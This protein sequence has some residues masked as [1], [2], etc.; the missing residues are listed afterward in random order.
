MHHLPEELLTEL[1]ERSTTLLEG[2]LFDEN[3]KMVAGHYVG[4]NG[5]C[6]SRDTLRKCGPLAQTINQIN[7]QIGSKKVV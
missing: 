5:G 1:L 4:G 3:G 2:V 7:A 6:I